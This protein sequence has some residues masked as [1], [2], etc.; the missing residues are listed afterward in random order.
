MQN[1]SDPTD[2]RRAIYWDGRDRKALRKFLG[3]LQARWSSG[4][5]FTIAGYNQITVSPGSYIW[6]DSDGYNTGRHNYVE[7]YWH[8]TKDKPECQL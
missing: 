2:I 5:S 6:D 1:K 7:K 4:G 8:V 3:S